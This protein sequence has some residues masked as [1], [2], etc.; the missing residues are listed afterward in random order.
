MMALAGGNHKT[1]DLK[2]TITDKQGQ[3]LAGVKIHI[4]S[5]KRDIY[6]DFEGQFSIQ[7]L[8]L[9]EQSIKLS[10]ISFEEKE[11]KLELDQLSSSLHLELRSK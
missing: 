1:T 10:Y 9:K 6:T 7:D 8:P 2:G 3:P 11:V 5:L 4:P